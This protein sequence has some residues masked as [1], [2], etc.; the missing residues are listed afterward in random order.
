MT[1]RTPP[2]PPRPVSELLFDHYAVVAKDMLA[3]LLDLL[4]AIRTHFEGDLD[5]FIVFLLIAL[6]TAQDPRAVHIDVHA[7][8]RGEVERYPSLF[9]NVR[10]IAASTGIPYETARRKVKRLIEAGWVERHE[11]YLTITPA[12]SMA[13]REMREKMFALVESDHQLV[14]RLLRMRDR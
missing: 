3:P 9:T 1:P 10:S 13:F 7:V 4:V 8:R 14:E 6:R 11:E 12:A 5:R 2:G